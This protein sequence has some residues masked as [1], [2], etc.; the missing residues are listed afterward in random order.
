MKIYID[1]QLLDEKDA[2]ISVFDHGLLYGDG[3]F[4]GIRIYSGRVFRLTEHLKRLYACA[5]AISL[6]IPIT[7]EEMER[8]TVE[9]VAANGLR[10]GYIRLVVTRG[11]GTLGLD[12][13]RCPKPSV[14]II[15][16]GIKLYPQEA[17][18]HGLK[19]IT[20]ATRRPAPAALSPQVKSLNYLNNVMA[21]IECLQAGCD[22]GIMLNEQGY[23]AECTGDNVFI[24]K[25]GE[26]YT[27][28]ISSG[29]LDGITR[30]AVME[31]LNKMSIPCHEV[32]MTRF[33]VYTADECFLTGTAAEALPA[34]MLDTRPIGS[35]KPG[36]TTLKIIE[37][38]KVLANSEGSP[39][40]YK[41]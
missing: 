37:A 25:N 34:V 2:K 27:P 38:F 5:R 8:A 32:M 3:V 20:C 28:T 12:P 11:V 1:G 21:K 39:V 22:E 17:Y 26:V 35:G 13:N 4:E 16:A 7:F 30:R 23:V 41:E 19:L 6:N 40:P 18:D 24:I 14:I 36:P 9:T 29:A 10:D 33:D 15:A 31:L